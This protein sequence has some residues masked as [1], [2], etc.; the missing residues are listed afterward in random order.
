MTGHDL[1]LQYQQRVD[2]LKKLVKV[3]ALIGSRGNVRTYQLAN[4]LPANT[5]TSFCYPV[6]YVNLIVR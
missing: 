6:K 4:E 5:L 2:D 1:K 3:L